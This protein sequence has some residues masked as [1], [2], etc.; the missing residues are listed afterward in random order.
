MFARGWSLQKAY[1]F[2]FVRR[3]LTFIFSAYRCFQ[4]SEFP[5]N[6]AKEIRLQRIDFGARYFETV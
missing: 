4:A 2:V 5:A 3:K 6:L 1:F